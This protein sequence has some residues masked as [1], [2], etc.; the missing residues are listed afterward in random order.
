MESVD[1]QGP[2]WDSDWLQLFSFKFDW[3]MP[4]EIEITLG[5][6][7]PLNRE[8]LQCVRSTTQRSSF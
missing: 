4:G 1:G 3:V 8:W 5:A 2:Q 7:H 6:L